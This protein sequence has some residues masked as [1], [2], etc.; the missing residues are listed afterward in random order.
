MRSDATETSPPSRAMRPAA[1]VL[2]VVLAYLP[3]LRGGYIWDDD[4]YVT[5]N[6]SLR[7]V[8]GLRRIWLEPTSP[9]VVAQYYPL[10]ETA[11]WLEYQL[12]GAWPAGY[13][14]VNVLL[15]ATSATLL[16]RLLALLGVPAAWVVAALW[17]VHPVGVESVAWV[18]ELKNVLSGLCFFAA[19]LAYVRFDRAAFAADSSEDA[20]RRWGW[21][22]VALGLFACAL[23]AKSV[24]SM[25]PAALLLVVWWRRGTIRARDVVPLLP[26][27]AAG[28]ASGTATAWME[29]H[30]VGATGSEWSFTLADRL[31]IGG[32][33]VWFYAAKLVWPVNLAFNYERWTIDPADGRQWAFPAAA[34][35]ALA[36]LF[37]AR[38]R[39]GRGPL[40]AVLFFVGTVTPAL[41][42]F[43][44]YPMRYSFVADHFQ[45]LASIGVVALAVGA[46][47]A[48]P[49][50][51]V[52]AGTAIV[53][54]ATLTWIRAGAFRNS[55][56]IWRDTLA[57]NPTSWLAHH[58]LVRL[59]SASGES[60]KALAEAEAAAALRPADPKVASWLGLTLA[61]AGRIDDA[62][63][64][65][66]RAIALDPAVGVV[67][68]NFGYDLERWGETA[69]AERQYRTALERDP[70]VPSVRTRLGRILADQGDVDGAIG[71][72][73]QELEIVP[74]SPSAAQNLAYA[75]L[76]LGRV[77]EAEPVL[78][79]VL[80]I[81]PRDAKARNMLATILLQRGDTAGAERA[82][83]RAVEDD[84]NLAETHNSLGAVL[85][86]EAR[87]DEAIAEYRQALRIRPDYANAQRNLDAALAEKERAG[88]GG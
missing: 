62:R 72:Y 40:A 33:A 7:S 46:G 86:A 49:G 63:R 37:A 39:I 8:E 45:Y 71:L 52:V 74:D 67:H 34:G 13:H 68:Y 27:L 3:A 85:A 20:P 2:L 6:L 53:T 21:Y 48:I 18:T 19:A 47:R 16:W 87:W 65:H 79:R 75:L 15:H 38:A 77:D 51:A 57:K 26:F 69:A 42:F 60:A 84:P 78:V 36:L 56:T 80:V 54:L 28:A 22:A 59:Y 44:V 41:G 1:L 88:A 82:L 55:E 30:Q 31:L 70:T 5:D 64:A 29:R 24:T 58:S 73:R 11:F 9:I 14:V 12:W 83:R 17:A 43:D 50:R 32:R 66:E 35:I 76:R 4:A 25:L 61:A 23:L 10:T 81:N